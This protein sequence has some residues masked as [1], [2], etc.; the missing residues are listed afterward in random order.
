MLRLKV[1]AKLLVNF[2][3]RRRDRRFGAIDAPQLLQ[4]LAGLP[5]LASLRQQTGVFEAAPQIVGLGVHRRLEQRERFVHV[6]QLL[7]D[8]GERFNGADMARIFTK[9]RL[10]QRPRPLQSALT[11]FFRGQLYLAGKNCGFSAAISP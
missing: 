4:Q 5:D 6:V 3:L 9:D 8:I 10:Q 7:G 2:G 1:V 11:Q